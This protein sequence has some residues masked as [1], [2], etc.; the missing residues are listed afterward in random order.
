LTYSPIKKTHYGVTFRQ[1]PQ[2]GISNLPIASEVLETLATEANPNNIVVIKPKPIHA[3]EG[4]NLCPATTFSG[5][6]RGQ[7]SGL[8]NSYK[9]E[10][11]VGVF[12]SFLKEFKGL[13]NKQGI[14][15]LIGVSIL[16][17]S[18]CFSTS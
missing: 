18:G 15:T 16:C 11:E 3:S 12:K 17:P 1:L 2:V 10:T 14:V 6:S 7:L 13:L 5:V 8:I 9:S 4:P